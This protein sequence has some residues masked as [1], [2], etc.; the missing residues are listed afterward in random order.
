MVFASL[1]SFGGLINVPHNVTN[2]NTEGPHTDL[3]KLRKWLHRGSK[4]AVVEAVEIEELK[5]DAV[6]EGIGEGEFVVLV[7]DE[8]RWP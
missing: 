5:D 8:R 7:G 3:E 1:C 6:L 4:K 2:S